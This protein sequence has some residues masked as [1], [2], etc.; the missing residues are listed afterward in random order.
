MPVTE[1]EDLQTLV[2]LLDVQLDIQ[3]RAIDS[4]LEHW[5]KQ[6]SAGD[7]EPAEPDED[8]FDREK[9]PGL[10]SSA[11]LQV[12]KTVSK[13][14]SVTHAREKKWYQKWKQERESKMRWESI[15]ANVMEGNEDIVK[16]AAKKKVAS[17][18]PSANVASRTPSK[19]TPSVAPEKAVSATPST[20]SAAT[21]NTSI[22]PL[23][24]E[25]PPLLPA[26]IP[27]VAKV[28]ED[29]PVDEDEFFDA[30]DDLN[31]FSIEEKR[32]KEIE[33]EFGFAPQPEILVESTKPSFLSPAKS[34]K[35]PAAETAMKPCPNESSI[36][37]DSLYGY[38]KVSDLRLKLPLDPNKSTKPSLSV[39]SFLKSAIGKDLSKVTLPVFFNEPL[40]M[41]Q[42]MCED[43]E[44]IELLSLAAR[45]G[46]KDEI[47]KKHPAI[48]AAAQKQWKLDQ[49]HQ[50]Q[51]EE[52]SLMRL[53]L[54]AAFAMSNYSS[55][56]GRTSKPFN[57]MLGETY[58]LVD[59]ERQYR[60]V[61]EQVCHHPPIS[62]CHCESTD[63]KFWTEVNVKSKFWGK[64]LE[65][66][67]MGVSH[68][69]LSVG[70]GMEH[71]SWKKV[72]TSV[73]NLIVGTLW[74]D[75]FGDMVI[76]NWRTGEEATLTFK[77]KS[78]GSW[79]GWGSGAK[80]PKAGEEDLNSGG[81]IVGKVCD[82]AGKIRFEIKGKWD[83]D[84]RAYNVSPVTSP[85]L[86]KPITLWKRNSL[87]ADSAQNFDF[88]HLALRMNQVTPELEK[89]LPST[90]SRLRPDQK[91][92][93]EG[94]WD[95]ANESKET[96]ERRQREER[97]VIVQNFE[98][99]GLPN[100]P[101]SRKG[102]P[103]GEDWWVPRWF[104]RQ[105]DEDTQ[106]ENWKF[107]QD[108]WECRKRRAEH[109]EAWPDWVPALFDNS[110]T[111]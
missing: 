91:A 55:T 78:T 87:P 61:S 97:K 65:V 59:E 38:P 88:S 4:V 17:G 83:S 32:S 90:D 42:R 66:H 80:T 41:L 109:N 69:A 86:S 21:A 34:A 27:G 23:Q 49:L 89:V 102:I 71:Y 77:P 6:D 106:E 22:S 108:Y 105:M 33:K 98:Q 43:V 19:L 47:P 29:T 8:D 68:V 37:A 58:E 44:Y 9:V 25:S 52:A 85:L 96:L 56:V 14:V 82:A 111:E 76:R 46:A 18:S 35:S 20:M 16:A 39:W 73:N 70:D 54:V 75:H 5:P 45:C 92:L 53:M 60:Y 103:M 104:E 107:V 51:K 2:Y 7:A 57:P 40:S 74:I 31:R 94:R 11:R 64:S 81:H 50:L 99:R 79:F 15:V 28:P 95:D 72:T 84:L 12:E 26:P 1:T 93:E 24:T 30:I 10:L 67:P 3:Q 36:V 48:H 101:P 13:I 110:P 62:A 63:Y 100:G